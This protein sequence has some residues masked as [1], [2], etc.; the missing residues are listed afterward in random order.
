MKDANKKENKDLETFLPEGK[1][2]LIRGK[3][4]SIKP[5]VLKTRSVVLR[6]LSDVFSKS[7]AE[8]PDIAMNP[9]ALG[10][11]MIQCAGDTLIDV[12]KVATEK[13]EDWLNQISMVEEVRIIR[14][15]V[16]VNDFPFLLQE[17]QSLR[18]LKTEESV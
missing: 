5:F 4:I 3:E 18:D 6:V 10:L 7:L 17:I 11:K 15:I 16:E 12:Y 8:S 9:H 1:K 13:S 2:I 14:T